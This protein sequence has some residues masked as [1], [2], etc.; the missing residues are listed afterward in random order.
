VDVRQGFSDQLPLADNS[1]SVVVCNNVLL[2]VPREKIPASLG[3]MWRVAKPGARVFVGEIPYVPQKDP[4]P[5]FTSRGQMLSYLYRQHGFRTWFGMLRRMAW[6]QI[7]GRP[8]VNQLGTAVSFFATAKEFISMAK[9]SG[10]EFVK[11]WQHEDP[12][13]RNDY[14]FKKPL[15]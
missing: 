14:L 4:T 7:T 2:I 9:E 15:V 13:D 1:A 5:Q 10:L 6:W 12:S 8:F 11:H 3:E